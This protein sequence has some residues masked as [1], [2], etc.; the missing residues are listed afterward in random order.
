M[1]TANTV[2]ELHYRM[3]D[4][5]NQLI[6]S[7][8]DGKPVLYMHGKKQMLGAFEAALDGRS[9]GDE[10]L[11][12]LTPDQAYGQRRDDAQ[13]RVPV[14]HLQGAKRWRAGMLAEVQ[15]E[16]GPRKVTVVKVG[17]FMADVDTNHPLAGKTLTFQVSI[18]STRDATAEELAHGHAHA[19]DHCGHGS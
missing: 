15:T 3:T 7:T 5:E 13:Q 8:F 4:S 19:G 9:A 16:H 11:L 17:K 1:I 10:L 2:V 14:K 12:T 6:E 18:L